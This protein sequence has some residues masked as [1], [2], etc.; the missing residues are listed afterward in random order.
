MIFSDLPLI[1]ASGSVG[2]NAPRAV[3]THIP[4]GPAVPMHQDCQREILW[5]E[6]QKH[7]CPRRAELYPDDDFQPPLES[8]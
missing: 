4:I 3:S 2:K 7:S 8:A 6:R 5:E 1:R